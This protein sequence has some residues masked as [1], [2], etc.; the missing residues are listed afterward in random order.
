MSQRMTLFVCIGQAPEVTEAE[1][2]RKAV[3]SRIDQLDEAFLMALGAYIGAAEEQG[4]KALAGRA[5]HLLMQAEPMQ[6]T[7][8][9]ADMGYSKD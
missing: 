1:A 6:T 5:R 9:V 4:D 8:K 2:I 7:C 3:A